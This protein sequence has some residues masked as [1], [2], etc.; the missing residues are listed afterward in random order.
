MGI[1]MQADASVGV[2]PLHPQVCQRASAFKTVDNEMMLSPVELSRA[3]N[4]IA[5]S[6]SIRREDP[7]PFYRLISEARHYTTCLWNSVQFWLCCCIT[8]TLLQIT[9]SL[10]ILPPVL[11]TGHVMWVCYIIVPLL[12]ASLMG[13]PTNP[14]IMEKPQSKNQ[15][16]FNSE[17]IVFIMWCYGA[18]FVPVILMVLFGFVGVLADNC[19]QFCAA[20]NCTCKLFHLPMDLENGTL[21]SLGYTEH[22]VVLS[23]AQNLAVFILVLNVAVISI[24]FVHREHSSWSRFPCS[25]MIWL[26]TFAIL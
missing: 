18:K 23:S 26:S 13:I 12:S 3:L 15:V 14:K 24:G 9:A 7:L 5:C 8:V 6:L 21:I 4:S 10:L 2:E 22:K 17:V 11:T 1:F 19:L 16:V 25:N 20:V